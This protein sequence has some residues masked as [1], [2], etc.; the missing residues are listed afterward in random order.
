MSGETSTRSC[1]KSMEKVRVMLLTMVAD[2]AV[3]MSLLLLIPESLVEFS[4]RLLACRTE[5]CIILYH[6]THYFRL[7]QSL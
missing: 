4:N 2:A 7:F 5:H 1:E 3:G 6:S